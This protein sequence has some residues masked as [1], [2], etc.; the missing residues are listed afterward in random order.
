MNVQWLP[1]ASFLQLLCL[2]AEAFLILPPSHPSTAERSDDLDFEV[3]T[4]TRAGQGRKRQLIFRSYSIL[5]KPVCFQ[6]KS[7]PQDI[8]MEGG[9]MPIS[10]R[11]NPAHLETWQVFAASDVMN[12]SVSWRCSIL[13][14]SIQVFKAG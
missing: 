1:S 9:T 6:T 7:A 14:A 3:G 11:G 13:N 10:D 5:Q 12:F 2:D 8:H 4:D